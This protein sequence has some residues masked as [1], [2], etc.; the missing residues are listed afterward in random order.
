MPELPEVETMRRGLAVVVGRRIAAVDFPRGPVRPLTV[1]PRPATIAARLAGR[2]IAAVE[3]RG[4]RV[5]LAIADPPAPPDAW[6]VIEPRMTG[7]V[8]LVDPP[9]VD[10]VRLVVHLDPSPPAGPSLRRRAPP[11]RVIVWD[12]RGLGTISLVDR[13]GLEAACGSTV[14]GP[15]G[16]VVTGVDLADRLGESRR[17]V[18]VALLDQRAVAGIGNIYASEI[19]HRVGI[20]P[21]IACRRLPRARWDAIARATRDVLREAVRLQGSSIGDR[22]YRTVRSR[23]GRFQA[24]HRVYGR[25]HAACGT[26]GTPVR[27]IV[28]AQRSTFFCPTCQGARG[29]FRGRLAADGPVA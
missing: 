13:R 2:S 26:C 12:R 21:R 10:H 20:D 11:S 14:L 28:Q 6:L 9:S 23:P 18:K 7:L 8:L 29:G 4:K 27:R 17:A 3:R 5:V 25:E 16:L 15:D 24:R 1:R 19:L 22:T